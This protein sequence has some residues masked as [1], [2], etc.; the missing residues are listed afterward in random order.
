MSHRMYNVFVRPA[1]EVAK[2]L[3]GVVM[4]APARR[5]AR[6]RA[7]WCAT[8]AALRPAR[9]GQDAVERREARHHHRGG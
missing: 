6:S 9:R 4:S 2:R 5:A 1:G 7:R 3:A 8:D